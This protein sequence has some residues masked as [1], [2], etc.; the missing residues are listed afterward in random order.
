MKEAIVYELIEELETNED[1]V[2]YVGYGISVYSVCNMGYQKIDEVKDI[3]SK[4]QFVQDMVRKFNT[5]KLSKEHF[6]ECIL[7]Q[8]NGIK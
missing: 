4:R 3:S 7:D 5:L 1:N 2:S 6:R 8:I